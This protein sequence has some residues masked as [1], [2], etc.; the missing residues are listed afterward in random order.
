MQGHQSNQDIRPFQ[1]LGRGQPHKDINGLPSM[2][3]LVGH[4]HASASPPP[5]GNSYSGNWTA[6][7]APYLAS[8][9]LS[10]WVWCSHVSL[11]GM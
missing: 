4:I 8:L 11:Q 6:P 9:G 10:P 5:G 1:P 3:D 7:L 2:Q